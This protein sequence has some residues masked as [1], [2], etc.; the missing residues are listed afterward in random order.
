VQALILIIPRAII[1]GLSDGARVRAVWQRLIARVAVLNQRRE[2]MRKV[3]LRAVLTVAALALTLPVL[4]KDAKPSTDIKPKTVAMNFYDSTNLGGTMIAPGKYKL[5]FDSDKVTVE[6]SN[7]KVVAT[8]PG[9]WESQQRKQASTGFTMDN[10]QV[11]QLFVE[12]EART[13]VLGS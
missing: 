10:G 2:M 7:K 11:K 5:V 8:V 4:A 13:F 9:H 12:G 6:D 3:I 1:T